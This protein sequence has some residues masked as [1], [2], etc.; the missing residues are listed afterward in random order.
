MAG[1]KIET[2][3]KIKLKTPKEIT[4]WKSRKIFLLGQNNKLLQFAA[5]LIKTPF[6]WLPKGSN[7]HS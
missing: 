3:E 7:I 6:D 5:V 1:K 2:A 4:F